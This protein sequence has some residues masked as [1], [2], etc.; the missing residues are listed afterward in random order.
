MPGQ[1]AAQA[2]QELLGF[3]GLRVPEKPVLRDTLETL[4]TGETDLVDAYLAALCSRKGLG[5]VVSFDR[6]LERLGVEILAVE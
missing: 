2:L 1:E 5:G 4:A 6:G 3:R